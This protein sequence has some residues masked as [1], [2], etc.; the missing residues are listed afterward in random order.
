M[1]L[2]LG[3]GASVPYNKPTIK[4]LDEIFSVKLEKYSDFLSAYPDTEYAL[5]AIQ[6]IIKFSE[7]LGGEWLFKN[8][9]PDVVLRLQDLENKIHA[10]IYDIYSWDHD[11]N[12]IASVIFSSLFNFIQELGSEITV[13]TTNYDKSVEEY[14]S[15]HKHDFRCIDGFFP[16]GER[17][18]WSRHH[19]DQNENENMRDVYLYKLHGSLDWTTHSI[20]GPIKTSVEQMCA[21]APNLNKDLLVY[22]TLLKYDAEYDW[23]FTEIFDEFSKRLE[24]QDA[25]VVVGFSFRDEK[26]LKRLIEFIKDGKKLILVDPDKDADFQKTIL[27]GL[28]DS[29]QKQLERNIYHIPAELSTSTVNS[30][31]NQIRDLLKDSGPD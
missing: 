23:L 31:I 2:F 24:V 8:H 13:F 28:S 9:A 16:P 25:C 10:A 4:K 15:Q 7:S 14:C 12:K 30:I 20:D 6:N 22:P 18:V 1:A 21:L 19:T 11:Y 5:T 26:I 17:F 3:A 27:N 29:D